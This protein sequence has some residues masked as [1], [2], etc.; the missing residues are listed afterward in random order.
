MSG[1]ARILLRIRYVNIF[2]PSKYFELSMP[3]LL[4]ECRTELTKT[5][6]FFSCLVRTFLQLYAIASQLS[7]AGP[8][9]V[10]KVLTLPTMF[11]CSPVPVLSVSFARARRLFPVSGRALNSVC[12]ARWTLS[13]DAPCP[14]DPRIWYPRS[15]SVYPGLARPTIRIE[16]LPNLLNILPPHIMKNEADWI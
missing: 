16:R 10:R 1:S 3:P 15:R 5:D 2:V 7:F 9:R 11:I 12:N 6:A 4:L 14:R 8:V 13:D